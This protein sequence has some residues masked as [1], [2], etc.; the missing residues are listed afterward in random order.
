IVIWISPSFLRNVSIG[1]AKCEW[2][3]FF[4]LAWPLEWIVEN[5]VTSSL[6]DLANMDGTFKRLIFMVM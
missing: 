3:L 5:V 1:V 2:C 6:K 4:I